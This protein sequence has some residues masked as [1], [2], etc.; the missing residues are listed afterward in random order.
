MQVIQNLTEMKKP[1][2]FQPE[3]NENQVGKLVERRVDITI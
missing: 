2:N 3:N 1:Q